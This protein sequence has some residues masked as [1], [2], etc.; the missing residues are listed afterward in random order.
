MIKSKCHF[1]LRQY[2][3]KELRYNEFLRLKR[4]LGS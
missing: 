3:K 4:C 2:L 1:S